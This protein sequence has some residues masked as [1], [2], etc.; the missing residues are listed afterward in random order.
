MTEIIIGSFVLL[1]LFALCCYKVGYHYGK[2]DGLKERYKTNKD[3]LYVSNNPDGGA[4]GDYSLKEIAD[5]I[6]DRMNFHEEAFVIMNGKDVNWIYTARETPSE[7]KKYF[8]KYLKRKNNLAY[9]AVSEW[10]DGNWETRT[11]GEVYAYYP[12][13]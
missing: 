10:K 5:H 1:A 4:M 6:G 3:R 9:I 8:I 13:E 11:D 2:A 7:G 12:V